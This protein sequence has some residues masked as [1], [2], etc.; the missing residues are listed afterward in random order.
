MSH[1]RCYQQGTTLVEWM[2]SITIGLILVAGM[3]TLIAQQSITQAELEKSSRQIENG[4][5]A[6]H[7]LNEDIQLAGYYGEFS[8]VGGLTV[9]TAMP[10][11]CA[12]AVSAIEPAMAFPVQGYDNLTTGL[13]TCINAANHVD[14]TDILVLRRVEPV[15]VAIASAASAA[16]YLQSGLTSSGLEFV[17]KMDFGSNATSFDLYKKDKT[18]LAPLRKFM[19]HIY[20]VSPCSVPVGTNC[21]GSADGGKPIP[22]LK[23]WESETGNN[24]SLVEGIENMQIDYGL[25]NSCDPNIGDGAP[26][27]PFVTN[28]TL[29]DW[30]KV[31]ALRVHLLARSNESSAGYLD[32]K[33][34]NLG[35]SGTTTAT[36][37]H[38]KRRV[39]SQ[40]IRVVN[41]SSRRDK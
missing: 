29:G 7:V 41:P 6:M 12:V 15:A 25:D 13:S 18:T 39:F 28:P 34:Y 2:V 8:N 20:F 30:C 37:D 16:V 26:D 31:M 21:S 23:V 40:L 27:G 38:F 19:V 35:L 33:T 11:P 22:T 4:R 17:K 9:P 36:N 24:T 5:Y 1:G 32:T 10:D 14:G 3:A